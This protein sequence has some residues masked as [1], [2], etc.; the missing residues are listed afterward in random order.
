MN[1]LICFKSIFF[2]LILTNTFIFSQTIIKGKIDFDNN[3]KS[4]H[5]SIILKQGD[6]TIDYS[7]SNQDNTYSIETDKSGTF[8][9]FFSSLNFETKILNIEISIKIKVIEKNIIL[10]YKPIELNEV[11][12]E[13]EK[14]IKIKSDTIVFNAKSFIQGNEQVVEDLLKKIPGINISPDGTIKV[15]N[16]EIEKVMIDGDDMFE[17]GY[18]ILTKNMPVNPIDKIELLQNYSNNRHL[19][20]IESSNKVALNLTLKENYKRQWFG[21]M[22]L[23]YGLVSENRYEVRSNLMNFGKKSKYYFLTNLNN[24]GDNATGD[25]NHLI[26]PSSFNEPGNIGNDKSANSLLS[27][28]SDLPNLKLK[29]INFNNAKM[30]SLNSI[31][32]LSKKVKLKTLG[33]LN[34]DENAFIKNSFKSFYVGATNFENFENFLGKKTQITGFS[35][36]DLIYDISK[37]KTIEYTGKFNIT[38]EKNNSDLLFNSNILNEQLK[39]NNQLIDQKIV[40]TNKFKENKVF[41]FSGRYINEKT[42]QNYSVNQFIFNDL[43]AVN[44]NNTKQYSQNKMQFAGIETHLLDKKENGD[45]FEIKFGN[46]L[47]IDALNTNFE[48]LNDE[49]NIALPTNY[50]N[51][52][53]Y[54]TNNLYLSA[55]YSFKLDNLTLST[56]SDF[57]QLFNKI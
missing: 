7:F 45:L 8:T 30:L 33:F 53:T 52:L 49:N 15:G 39:S 55:K 21:N 9:L 18:K 37:N 20:G 22:N 1:K 56:Q 13:K 43:F 50:Q 36:I 4:N 48:L 10:N 3:E 34:I 24:I 41:L 32:T 28:S 29:R 19:K 57:H 27:L 11:I 35:K 38:N 51:N 6:N 46:Q 2:L 47:R 5:V 40:F 44:A 12:I 26:R 42:P 54:S 25:I 17:K 23:G 31:F 14:S 16:Q